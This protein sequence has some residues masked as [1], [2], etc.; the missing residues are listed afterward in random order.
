M[1]WLPWVNA[2]RERLYDTV[3]TKD[4]EVLLSR[5]V[6]T[7]LRLNSAQRQRM[8][9]LA[10]IFLN[11]K[12]F[13]GCGGLEL[14]EDMALTIASQACLLLVGLKEIKVP[15]PQ[16]HVLRIYPSAYR[17]SN[18]QRDGAL[19]H[20]GSARLGES[21]L[22]G[23]IV[24]AWDHVRQGG[25]NPNDGQNVVLHEFAHQLDTADGAADGAPI[26]PNR[27]LYAPWAQVMGQEY[28][29]LR[30]TLDEGLR[31][32]IRAY[33][34]TNPAEFFAVV[35]EH[36]FEQAQRMKESHP[37]LFDMLREYYRVDP[38]GW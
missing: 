10:Q 11:E 12:T 5:N 13:E 2:R 23:Y 29:A 33:G 3:M 20:V 27:G 9:G 24:L 31:D 35:T 38:S 34:A 4:E 26:L 14:T 8:D 22:R 36:F 1:S 21:S 19:T 7:R 15:Y 17:V 28:D 30:E 32:M 37:A 6:P 16:L 18:V 25:R